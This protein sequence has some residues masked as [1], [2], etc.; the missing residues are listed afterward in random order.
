MVIVITLLA[1]SFS[2]VNYYE[3]RH[4]YPAVNEPAVTL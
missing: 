2:Y 4:A 3:A 1:M